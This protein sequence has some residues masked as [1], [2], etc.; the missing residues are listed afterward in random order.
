MLLIGKLGTL[1]MKRI[2][3]TSPSFPR[4]ILFIDDLISPYKVYNKIIFNSNEKNN[5]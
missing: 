2:R 4:L 1:K 5:V 3:H